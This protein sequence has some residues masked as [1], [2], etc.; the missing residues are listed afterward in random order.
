MVESL[1]ASVMTRRKLNAEADGDALGEVHIV[2]YVIGG[3]NGISKALAEKIRCQV[4]IK[5]DIVESLKCA[6]SRFGSINILVN[7]T[8]VSDYEMIYD[9][10]GKKPHS[11]ELFKRVFVVNVWGL[12]NVI[13]LAF[14]LM[15]EN[16]PDVNKQRSVIVNLSSTMAYK[17]SPGMIAY[18]ATKSAVSSMMMSLARNVTKKG[19]R[20][21]GVAPGFINTKMTG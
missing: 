1:S 13:R 21:V 4:R 9:F 5:R 2:A 11:V 8:S 7:N 18:N 10:K 19:I 15:A 16:K 3:S 6:K 17:A 20:V 12:F 14:G